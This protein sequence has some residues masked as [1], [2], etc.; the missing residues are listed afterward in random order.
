MAIIK[1]PECGHQVSDKAPLCPSCGIHIAGNVIRCRNCGYLYL[2]D[3]H[4]CPNCH[5]D[6][7][8]ETEEEKNKK[9]TE[10][11]KVT[12][13][14]TNDGTETDT[15]EDAINETQDD[16]DNEDEAEGPAFIDDDNFNDEL[17]EEDVIDPNTEEVNE[18]I[19]TE[20]I[21]TVK[22]ESDNGDEENN[23]DSDAENKDEKPMSGRTSALI[24]S[25]VIAAILCAVLFYF[26]KDA[27]D[28]REQKDFEK[29]LKSPDDPMALQTYLDNN[30][31]APRE[32]LDSIYNLLEKQQKKYNPNDTLNKKTNANDKDK[33]K[34]AEENSEELDWQAASQ[35]KN[36]QALKGF[37]AKYPQ[38]THKKEVEDLIE[39]LDWG[40]AGM[41]NT[42]EAYKSYLTAHP[43]GKHAEEAKE[44]IK[45]LN[46][47]QAKPEDVEKVRSLFSSFFRGINAKDKGRLQSTTSAGMNVNYSGKS[48]SPAQYM[49]D[50]YQ[51]DITNMLWRLN[52]DFKVTKRQVG[53]GKYEY[54]ANFTA[55]QEVTRKE[56]GK[57]TLKYVVSGRLNADGKITSLSVSRA[58]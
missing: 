43:E 22:S 49:T 39:A 20:Q 17:E 40:A 19:E 57:S 42:I 46:A 51:A 35:S 10:Q 45:S 18:A 44:K 55:T 5:F 8:E 30:K 34:K 26:Y 3:E 48:G 33:E 36:T 21:N 14:Q 29:A 41:S 13:E 38:T 31:N 11:E 28:Q 7:D 24:I 37:L 50:I 4:I 58:N 52:N 12:K 23:N 16:E 53:E 15:L 56:Q 47:L 25:F 6:A 2:K 32:H 9:N 27:N 1:C 54:T